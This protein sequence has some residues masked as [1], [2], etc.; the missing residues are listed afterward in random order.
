MPAMKISSTTDRDNE[1]ANTLG[2]PKGGMKR[3]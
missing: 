3:D 1:T 2:V